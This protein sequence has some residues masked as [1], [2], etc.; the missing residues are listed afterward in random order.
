MAQQPRNLRHV[1]EH[2]GRIGHADAEHAP[3]GHAGEQQ[4]EQLGHR[5]AD[6]AAVRSGV[7]RRE[8][9]FNDPL[10]ERVIHSLAQR[11]GL[12]RTEAAASIDGLAVCA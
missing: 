8:P 5:R 9:N 7:F 11:G 6:V 12:V 2:V 3:L 4:L 1:L 10:G